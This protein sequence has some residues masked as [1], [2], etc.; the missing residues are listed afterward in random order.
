MFERYTE[1]ARRLV[2]F[3]R[4]EAA[5]V[6]S[7]YIETAHLLLAFFR[8]EKELLAR[9]APRLT[10]E[11]VE[12]AIRKQGRVNEPVSTAIDMPLSNAMKRVLTY[13]AEEAERVRDRNIGSEHLFLGLLREPSELAAA[14]LRDAG[15]TLETIRGQ[16]ASTLYYCPRCSFGV[17]DPLTCGDCSAVICRIC[18]TPLES[19]EELGIG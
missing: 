12:D 17:R 7:L 19:S 15:V 5:V 11:A 2:F 8:E 10:R 6:G 3:A 18:G 1:G 13:G 16:I 9:L 4:Y 14:I